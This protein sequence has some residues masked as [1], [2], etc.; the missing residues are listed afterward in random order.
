[1]GSS[2]IYPKFFKQPI[3]ESELLN[4]KLEQTNEPYAVAK[5]A[6][7][8]LCQSYN[9]QYKREYISIMPPNLYGPN[10]NYNLETA[11]VLPAL[12]RKTYEAKKNN[13]TY[14][15]IWGNGKSLRE[16][17][18]VDDLAEACFFLLKQKNLHIL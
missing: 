2:C 10:D 12:I 14:I 13:K 4:G 18:H 1:M 5:I 3:K 9:F 8:K 15:E 7:V 16:F 11:H 6:G 17:M